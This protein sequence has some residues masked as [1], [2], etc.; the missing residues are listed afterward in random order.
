MNA[1]NSLPTPCT[2]Q[3]RRKPA[4][5]IRVALRV[6]RALAEMSMAQRRML[7]LRLSA[8]LQLGDPAAA[9][10][11]FGEFMLRTSG[12]LLREPSAHQRAAGRSVR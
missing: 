5:P 4:A 9:P 7:N 1:T 12:S 10:D 8:E 2:P 6:R 3:P 11:D